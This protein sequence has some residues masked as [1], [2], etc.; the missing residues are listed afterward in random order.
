MDWFMKNVEDI[1]PLSPMQQGMLF[2]TVYGSTPGVYLEQFNCILRGDLDLARFKRAWE[3][4]VERYPVL[5]SA[6]VWKGLEEPLQVVRQQVSLPWYE[7][8]WSEVSPDEQRERL[9]VY[10]QHDRTRGFESNKA[11]LIRVAVIRLSDDAHQMVLTFDH[12][13]LDGWSLSL[14]LKEVFV[15]YRAYGDGEELQLESSRPYSTSEGRP[16]C[17]DGARRGTPHTRIAT[18]VH[19]CLSQSHKRRRDRRAA[20]V[21]ADGV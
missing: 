7:A 12:L 4:I 3:K 16:A 2:H 9:A 20:G 14:V 11:P 15:L 5:R 1:Y 18:R 10:L 6:F 17:L 13:L 19:S 21:P 8:D